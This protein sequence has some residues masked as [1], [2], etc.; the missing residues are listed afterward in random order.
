MIATHYNEKLLCATW[1]QKC[2]IEIEKKVIWFV[3]YKGHVDHE[4]YYQE[5]LLLYVPW[6][7]EDTDLLYGQTSNVNTFKVH[8]RTIQ[9][10]MQEYKP[11][12]QINHRQCCRWITRYQSRH[13]YSNIN[14]WWKHRW[15][16]TNA[17]CRKHD[18]YD[19]NRPSNK[20][21]MILKQSWTVKHLCS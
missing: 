14:T 17:T 19:P 16:N 6:P 1:N 3:N 13:K 18:Y 7:N 10:K 9:I 4:N 21:Y 20:G 5:H 15:Y 8:T 11:L 2:G 12:A